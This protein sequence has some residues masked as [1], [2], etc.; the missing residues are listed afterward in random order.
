MVHVLLKGAT[1]FTADLNGRTALD[2]CAYYNRTACLAALLS[3]CDDHRNITCRT[4]IYAVC[5]GHT[6]CAQILIAHPGS[7][8]MLSELFFDNIFD[9][10]HGLPSNRT[11]ILIAARMNFSDCLLA[12]TIISV[13]LKTSSKGGA[14]EADG[15][16]F[17]VWRG[18][19]RNPPRAT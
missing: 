6:N 2:Y 18:I 10:D 3:A 7:F 4:L 9:D 15:D 8:H 11:A 5:R 19:Y 1:V 16:R 12:L 17:L 13:D 14:D